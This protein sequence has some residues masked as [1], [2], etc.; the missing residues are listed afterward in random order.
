MGLGNYLPPEISRKVVPRLP[1]RWQ[2]FTSAPTWA[3]AEATSVGY[4]SAPVALP[5]TKALPTQP[6]AGNQT[7]LVAAFGVALAAREPRSGPVSVVDFGGYDG[8][9]ADLIQHLLPQLAFD[10]VVVDL[11][12]VVEVMSA[13]SRP[14]LAFVSDPS[15]ALEA[16]PDVILASASLNYIANP[17]DMLRVM[18]AHGSF[19]VL[20]RLPLWPIERHT[21]AVQHTQRRPVD[22]SYPTWFFSEQMFMSEIPLESEVLFDFVCPDDRA[23]FA[24]HYSTYRG[25]VIAT[26]R[27]R[28][29]F[30]S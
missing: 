17:T 9:H 8:K 10:W 2:R 4:V 12:S 6:L 22:I 25:L 3:E 13:R 20:T 14:G 29:W 26:N 18:C 27:G 15:A 24:G 30:R 21:A 19:V 5:S 16:G 7:A 1:R 23:G 11:P 28:A